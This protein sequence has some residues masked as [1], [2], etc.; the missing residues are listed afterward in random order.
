MREQRFFAQYRKS[1][2]LPNQMV[3]ADPFRFLFRFQ[4]SPMDPVLHHQ[5]RDQRLLWSVHR[6][7]QLDIAHLH[8][9]LHSVYFSWKLPAG[10][11]GKC[12][13]CFFKDVPA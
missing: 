10:E 6:L 5:P 1:Q 8:D 3:H 9:S 12:I 2:S 7:G 4:R 13:T 11:A